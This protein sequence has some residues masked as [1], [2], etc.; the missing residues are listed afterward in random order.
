MPKI[1]DIARQADELAAILKSAMQPLSQNE[2]AKLHALQMEI[3]RFMVLKPSKEPMIYPVSDG[4]P[5]RPL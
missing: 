1:P 2:I 4:R 5:K 3:E